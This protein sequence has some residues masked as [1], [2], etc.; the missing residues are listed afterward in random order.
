MDVTPEGRS[1]ITTGETSRVTGIDLT[2]DF[3]VVARAE[4]SRSLAES[5]VRAIAALAER[6]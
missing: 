2:E 6:R 5:R 1:D 4:F 3:V